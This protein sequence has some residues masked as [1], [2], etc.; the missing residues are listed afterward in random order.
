[1][2]DYRAPV[3]DLLFTLEHVAEAGRLTGWDAGLAAEVLAHGARWIDATIAPLD[4]I[5]DA[6]GC[7][8]EQGRVRMPPAFVAAYR[9]Y[10]EGGWPGLAL[11]DELG[12]QGLSPVL[13]AA[14]SEM[15][16]GACLSFQMVTSAG[17]SPARAPSWSTAARPS[18]A[19]GSPVSP[20]AS[21]WPPCA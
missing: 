8:L 1:M 12:G 21:G 20:P 17:A 11:P 4:P 16:S 19:F 10:A 7:R 5:G 15:L 13:A 9:Q 3:A 6:E 2:I 18:A 14:V